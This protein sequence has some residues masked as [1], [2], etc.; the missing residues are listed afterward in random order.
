MCRMVIFSYALCVTITAFKLIKVGFHIPLLIRL[1]TIIAVIQK[2]LDSLFIVK[3][4]V[5]D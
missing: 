5:A 2:M 4:I 3:Q 1:R